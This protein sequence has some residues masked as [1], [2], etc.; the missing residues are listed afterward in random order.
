V[1]PELIIAVI[2]GLF[3]L[4]LGSFLNVCIVRWGAEPKQSVVRPRSRCPRC[5]H[6]IR[7]FENIPVLSW[8]VL[9]G[10]CSSCHQPSPLLYPAVELAT[11]V[12][13][14]GAFV[15]LGPGFFAAKL[16]IAGTLLLGIA[17]SDARAYIIPHEF[18]L[19]GT[20][21]AL[22]LAAYPD[23]SGL[24]PALIG[25]LAGA[26]LVLLTGELTELL[27]GQ[28]AM[29]GGDCALMGMVGA[30]FGW[31]VVLPVI[32]L[33]AL[34]SL[35]L[36][37]ATTILSGRRE[38]AH[39]PAVDELS[40][41][42]P[43]LRWGKVLILI[44]GG[45]VIGGLMLLA[46]QGGI[47]GPV[48][49]SAFHGVLGAGL[50]YYFLVFAPEVVSRGMWTRVGGLLGFSAG[51]ATGGGIAWSRL[52]VGMLLAIVA[53]WVTRRREV[54]LSPETV[55]GLSAGGYVPFGVGLAIAAGLLAFTGSVEKI[56]RA[57]I[58]FAPLLGLG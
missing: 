17:V 15:A 7:W 51:V 24:V 36:Y 27:L 13:W 1:T 48:L 45:V 53:V 25:A 28:E 12:M 6:Q 19:G 16:A 41:G 52:A 33:G 8:V 2:A 49:R 32:G 34:V 14:A 10:R 57:F 42:S 20:A 50:A 30:F 43:G 46:L 18:S 31:H 47:L 5:G 39:T 58:E 54:A 26:G 23:P 56:R 37:I 29:G 9:R 22:L 21:I 4:I 40:T 35:L 3:G 11:G 55:A 38:I 44:I